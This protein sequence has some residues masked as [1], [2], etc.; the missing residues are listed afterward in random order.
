MVLLLFSLLLW[1]GVLADAFILVYCVSLAKS[2]AEVY[3]IYRYSYMRLT[4][5]QT[6]LKCSQISFDRSNMADGLR[7]AAN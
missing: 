7:I 1:Y 3:F 6:N 4:L 5:S 2:S